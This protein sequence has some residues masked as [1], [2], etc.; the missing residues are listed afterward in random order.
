MASLIS[1][2]IPSFLKEWKAQSDRA[3]R[4]ELE[5]KFQILLHQRDCTE[6]LVCLVDNE[7]SEVESTFAKGG[8]IDLYRSSPAVAA[9]KARLMEE[10][11]SSEQPSW[12]RSEF[13]VRRTMLL[14]S[15]RD[16]VTNKDQKDP[17]DAE[18]L[19]QVAKLRWQKCTSDFRKELSLEL[20]C[21]SGFFR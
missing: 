12:A 19:V 9:C 15:A 1:Q 20:E 21:I 13:F 4:L 6:R 14:D 18:S 3:I 2:C 17:I 11:M 10:I 5:H 7:W 8:T 16:I